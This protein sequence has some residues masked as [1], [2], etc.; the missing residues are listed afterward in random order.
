M[1]KP[2]MAGIRA[3][4]ASL[5]KGDE[6]EA[7]QS[8][9]DIQLIVP[10]AIKSVDRSDMMHS[11]FSRYLYI[12]SPTIGGYF[13]SDERADL[14]WKRKLLMKGDRLKKFFGNTVSATVLKEQ[15]SGRYDDSDSSLEEP[16]SKAELTVDEDNNQST[17]S[18]VRKKLGKIKGF[19]GESASPALIE[20]S[21]T[22]SVVDPARALTQKEKRKAN[23]KSEKLKAL[24]GQSVPADIIRAAQPTL[25]LVEF[26]DDDDLVIADS[27]F[28]INL[29]ETE[30]ESVGRRNDNLRRKKLLQILGDDRRVG[31]V[32]N[33]QFLNKAA[34]NIKDDDEDKVSLL[35]D[36]DK[37]KS[38][39]ACRQS[40]ATDFGSKND[41]STV[42]KKSLFKK[43]KKLLI[44][45]G[46]G[47]DESGFLDNLA[48]KHFQ[49][50]RF[51]QI[52]DNDDDSVNTID[53]IVNSNVFEEPGDVQKSRRRKL[54][55]VFGVQPEQI[56]LS[57][58]LPSIPAGSKQR[59]MNDEEKKK[60]VRRKEKLEG[61]LG[62]GFPVDMLRIPDTEHFDDK[63]LNDLDDEEILF[64]PEITIESAEDLKVLDNTKKARQVRR[65]RLSKILGENSKVKDVL[66]LQ[67]LDQALVSVC[68]VPENTELVEDLN[69]L[70]ELAIKREIAIKLF[71]SAEKMIVNKKLNK[72]VEL[73]G[74]GVDREVVSS[75]L[76]KDILDKKAK[77]IILEEELD[78]S[79]N[80]SD[81]SS[82]REPINGDQIDRI[83][84]LS[85]LL[86]YRVAPEQVSSDVPLLYARVL[87]EAE[88][89]RF[90]QQSE[91][92]GEMLGRAV[93][94]ELINN[95]TTPNSAQNDDLSILLDDDEIDVA[96]SSDADGNEEQR[97]QNKQR[98][99][100]LRKLLGDDMRVGKVLNL[101]FLENLEN[102]I[103]RDDK[104][105]D[106]LLQDINSLKLMA[107]QRMSI[108]QSTRGDSI[109]A[110]P[111]T[112]S[113]EERSLQ[114]K[115]AKKLL[116][117][118]GSG[119]DEKTIQK[120]LKPNA[121]LL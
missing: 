108:L 22:P 3:I 119:L 7:P 88:K 61:I 107:T 17:S 4:L 94:A 1:L 70:K 38:V 40:S 110:T 15:N 47:A 97:E 16:K 39:A 68:N 77:Q 103:D 93:P 115:R 83:K 105:H 23:R 117:L 42:E 27:N 79:G 32:L 106:S 65:S 25:S 118:L 62:R 34:S 60:M 36:L 48:Q 59:V 26:D 49:E 109:M 89:N 14:K 67:F 56:L 63:E 55:R 95:Y 74:D 30:D 54:S 8:E 75:A 78:S 44:L 41:L 57:N 2:H 29:G 51:S 20:Q 43:K 101:H 112:L 96:S 104:I 50:S 53:R 12:V 5:E 90:K 45:L 111:N 69:G 21:A 18:N 86:G 102:R 91:K 46:E 100:K 13:D 6:D 28:D 72:L 84:K 92:L 24:L 85:N 121:V 80:D 113:T 76:K 64:V 52:T 19:F 58:P 33:M 11:I 120:T 73:L 82:H 99:K 116:V 66:N 114:T 10:T 98:R 71:S 9:G 37:L 87:T 81:D 35:Q 31:T